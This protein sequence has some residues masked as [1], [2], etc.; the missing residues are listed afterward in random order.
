MAAGTAAVAAALAATADVTTTMAGEAVTVVATAS[1]VET[2]AATAIAMTLV[3]VAAL[4]VDARMYARPRYD[5]DLWEGEDVD[6]EG[7]ELTEYV[8]ECYDES[9]LLNKLTDADI[10][11]YRKEKQIM[12]SDPRCP[13]PIM[14]FDMAPFSEQVRGWL[15]SKFA[16]PTPVQAQGWP[17]AMQGHNMVARAVTGSGKT[18]GFILPGL[19]HCQKQLDALTGREPTGRP[20]VLVVSPTRE[21][22][23]QIHVECQKPAEIMGIKT[24]LVVG[25]DN[26]PAREQAEILRSEPISVCIG[27]AGRL[28]DMVRRGALKLN[29]V[30]Y[31][32]LDEADRM[33]DMGFSRDIRG[34]NRFIRPTRQVLMW[35]AT[36]PSTVQ[37]LAREVFMSGDP[38]YLKIGTNE[39]QVVDTINYEFRLVAYRDKDRALIEKIAPI[40]DKRILV[41]CNRKVD[42]EHVIQLVSNKL[43]QHRAA[44]THGDKSNFEREKA[45]KEFRDGVTNVLVASD[46][47]SR[48]IDVPKVALVVNY[49]LPKDLEQFVHRSGRTGRA[50]C[51]GD[52]FNLVTDQDQSMM[53]QIGSMLEK[54]GR[55]M[56]SFQECMQQMGCGYN[57]YGNDGY[58]T[59][60]CE[61]PTGNQAWDDDDQA[62]NAEPPQAQCWD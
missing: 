39:T 45:M 60:E 13:R 6:W 12:V 21:L 58:E 49:D 46:V 19:V 28:G 38:I 32:V 36:W 27:T 3:A 10:E 2:A 29:R 54:N 44:S 26:H 15:N 41:F 59:G 42:C 24:T 5:E 23:T 62:G 51:Q 33:L 34:M 61:Q 55:N 1:A 14:T 4:V 48:G 17:I 20:I 47:L 43:P 16:A 9:E 35:S 57:N 40:P 52:S 37:G 8:K 56:T 7:E 53:Y 11:Q 22:S 50:G 18:L 31:W 30:T 25:G